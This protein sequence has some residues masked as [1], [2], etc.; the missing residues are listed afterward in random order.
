MLNNQ[1]FGNNLHVFLGKF[2][3]GAVLGAMTLTAVC[4]VYGCGSNSTSPQT[5]SKKK[6]IVKKMEQKMAPGQ[7]DKSSGKM[8]SVVT[9]IIPGLTEEQIEASKA[10]AASNPKLEILP[11]LTLEELEKRKAEAIQ[12]TSDP[13]FKV[14]PGVTVREMRER[15]EAA[16]KIAENPN[17]EVFPGVTV[18]EMK[19]RRAEALRRNIHPTEPPPPPHKQK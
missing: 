18:Q 10:A 6:M 15:Q 2:F 12:K 14:F 7:L 5:D 3:K 11:G 16:R 4:L 1:K 17:F 9:E 13:N 8:G 19:E